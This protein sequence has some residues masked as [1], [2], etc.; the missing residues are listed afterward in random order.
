MSGKTLL[1]A[2]ITV[3][4]GVSAPSFASPVTTQ[5]IMATTSNARLTATDRRLDR[6]MDRI[7]RKDVRLYV[8]RDNGQRVALGQTAGTYKLN[9]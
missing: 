3:V 8:N 6:F 5:N 1:A 7:E 9:R 2:A 4:A